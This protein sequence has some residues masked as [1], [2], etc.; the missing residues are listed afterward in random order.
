MQS[1][2]CDRSGGKATGG[3]TIASIALFILG[4]FSLGISFAFDHST[5]G[6]P[7]A[8][9]AESFVWAT[10]LVWSAALYLAMF[11]HLKYRRVRR[12]RVW[13][14]LWLPASIALGVI[15]TA[16]ASVLCIILFMLLGDLLYAT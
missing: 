7:H 3:C 13:M 2:W 4:F 11:D 1:S 8:Q 14:A 9:P 10:M 6:M 15:A 12:V 16:V 5:F